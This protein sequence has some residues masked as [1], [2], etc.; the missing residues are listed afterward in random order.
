[1]IFN[2]KVP[3]VSISLNLEHVCEGR[4]YVNKDIFCVLIRLFGHELL[5]KREVMYAGGIVR[6]SKNF[7]LKVSL[8]S[9]L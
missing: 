4:F 1:M 7:F 2:L 3:F 5:T 8:Y 9:F 6:V